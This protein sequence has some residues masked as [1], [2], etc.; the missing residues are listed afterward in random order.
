MS[1]GFSGRSPGGRGRSRSARPAAAQVPG[2]LSPR[3]CRAQSD[4]PSPPLGEALRHHPG[5][6]ASPSPRPTRPSPGQAPS[7]SGGRSEP[8]PGQMA[9]DGVGPT[10][11]RRQHSPSCRRRPDEKE[12]PGSG[13]RWERRTIERRRG[14]RASGPSGP[15]RA[16][17]PPGGRRAGREARRWRGGG[18]GAA[19]APGVRRVRGT[20][21]GARQPA[22]TWRYPPPAP[23]P[24]PQ[25]RP[26]T[27]APASRP[28]APGRHVE[29]PVPSVRGRPW[30]RPE[31][32]RPRRGGPAVSRR[33]H[34]CCF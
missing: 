7:A 19:G 10:A 26:C 33:K 13:S 27:P 1:G 29:A 23:Q 9:T 4:R 32:R 28:R 18:C 24:G 3:R 17:P 6:T 16:A 22:G 12:R 8:P 11:R 34:S 30:P 15:G 21:S 25:P 5:P 2:A 31:P 14:E 20:G